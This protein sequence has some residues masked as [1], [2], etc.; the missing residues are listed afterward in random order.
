MD[1]L[2]SEIFSKPDNEIFKVVFFPDRIYH[3]AYLNATVSER[4]RYNVTEV[5]NKSDITFIKA[6]VFQ[7]GRF[8]ANV[9]RIEYHAIR[10]GEVT[11]EN[12][13]FLQMGIKCTLN[14]E[15]PGGS[16]VNA[17]VTLG[18]CSWVRAYQCEIWDTLEPIPGAVHHFKVLSQMGKNGAITHVPKLADAF[19]NIKDIKKIEITFRENET[20]EP[21][22]Y[23]INNPVWDNDYTRS[24]Q[25]PNTNEPSSPQNTV[26]VKNYLIDFQRG[27]FMDSANVKPVR[28]S[29]AM[30]ENHN[31]NFRPDGTNIVEMK[32]ILQ[33]ELGGNLVYFHEV[34]V[35][36][37]SFE[38]VHQHIGS[39]ELYYIVSGEGIAYM[40][41]D[42]D[43]AF[44]DATQPIVK[45]EI[46]CI[47]E[48]PVRE[49]PVKPGKIIYTKSGG[50][51]GIKNTSPTTPLIFV[52]FGYHCS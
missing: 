45:Q 19:K 12:N 10:L 4:Y 29:N 47:G 48:K 34:N 27:W 46:Y 50:I 39:E 30:M 18:Y 25:V 31:P 23:K 44:D 52:A 38:G 8:L 26:E 11:R 35:T 9:F 20:D 15:L 24:Y 32:W 17:Q 40:G 14:I 28:Y 36:P 6:Q 5:R 3:A 2:F 41:H 37:G 43:P 42:D 33:R 16:K 1:P 49:L 21:F 7:D 22:G 51:H 13:R